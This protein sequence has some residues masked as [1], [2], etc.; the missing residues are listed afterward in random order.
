MVYIVGVIGGHGMKRTRFLLV[1]DVILFAV[2]ILL[3]E[4]RFEGLALHEWIGLALIPLVIIHILF[5]WR[6]IAATMS[7][8][9]REST[10]RLRINAALN[11]FLFLAFVVTMFSGVMTSFI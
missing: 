3:S 5:G 1:L 11:F 9:F 6:W 2:L 7:R 8:L 4:P 10:W